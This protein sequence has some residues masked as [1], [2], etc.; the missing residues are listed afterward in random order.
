MKSRPLR[1]LV[2]SGL[3]FCLVGSYLIWHTVHARA[4]PLPELQASLPVATV[5]DDERPLP[6]FSLQR[7]GGSVT[8]AT[9]QN[10][11][12]LLF[13]GYTHCPEVCPT[14]LALL[15]NVKMRMQELNPASSPQV[16][17]VSVDQRRDSV[18]LLGNFVRSFDPG[19]IGATASDEALGPLTR[20]LGVFFQRNDQHDSANY[21]V[22]HTTAIYL[23]DPRGRL[24]AV[25]E[26][27]QQ[28]PEMARELAAMT[29]G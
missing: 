10:H 12:T 24:K 20:H 15:R 14:E 13:F 27:P 22:D 25:F 26:P 4:R 2:A 28:A 7:L 17:F 3:L 11:W 23:I 9:L 6:E 1:T 29:T 18:A 5:I 19:F 16:I 21:T 8:D